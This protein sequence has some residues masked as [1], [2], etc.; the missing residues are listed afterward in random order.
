MIAAATRARAASR[1]DEQRRHDEV[2][3]AL[4]RPGH[5][6]QHR[7]P[8]LE[9]RHA[10]AG[11]VLALVDEELGRRRGELHLHAVAVRELHDIED[12]LLVEVRLCE[13]ELVRPLPLEQPPAGRATRRPGWPGDPRDRPDDLDPDPAARGAS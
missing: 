9:E 11:H 12:G 2:E 13:H 1:H 8:Q 4:R 10:L 7:R 6:R 3:R 5:A